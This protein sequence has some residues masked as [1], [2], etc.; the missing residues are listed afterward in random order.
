MFWKNTTGAHGVSVDPSG[1]SVWAG[2]GPSA[3]GAAVS[4]LQF[5]EGT[6]QRLVEQEHGD[7]VLKRAIAECHRYVDADEHK[8]LSMARLEAWRTLP[9]D[10]DLEAIAAKPDAS[11]SRAPQRDE[12]TVEFNPLE[13]VVIRPYGSTWTTT[14]STTRQPTR[15]ASILVS[16]DWLYAVRPGVHIVSKTGEPV[17]T[18][19]STE[20]ALGINPWGFNHTIEAHQ[21]FRAGGRVVA[22]W[23]LPKTVV[24]RDLRRLIGDHGLVELCPRYGII[25]R[26]STDRFSPN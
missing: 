16:G 25:G 10:P 26:F 4:H 1:V 13:R 5:L 6:H 15:A 24:D 9:D 11:G 12:W 14:S 2:R 20:P 21:L 8:A 19:C 17:L 18:A 7:G 23:S 22:T 3:S